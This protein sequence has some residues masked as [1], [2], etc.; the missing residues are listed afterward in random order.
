LTPE[1]LSDVPGFARRFF[2]ELFSRLPVSMIV[3]FDAL[4]S[5][6]FDGVPGTDSRVL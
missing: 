1:Y 2:R 3:L 4:V 5:T 6:V